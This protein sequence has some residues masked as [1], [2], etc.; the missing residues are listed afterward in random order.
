MDLGEVLARERDE[1]GSSVG[2][3]PR[4]GE[5]S[6]TTES[7]CR[8]DGRPTLDGMATNTRTGTASHTTSAARVPDPHA[9]ESRSAG[10][11]PSPA[12]E[13]LLHPLRPARRRPVREPHGLTAAIG[14]RTT[15]A[16]TA[17]SPARL[18]HRVRHAGAP[19]LVAP[20]A[21]PDHSGDLLGLPDLSGLRLGLRRAWA[22]LA[23]EV[24]ASAQMDAR[25]RARR[26][27][28]SAAMARAGVNRLT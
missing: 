21:V 8:D 20:T 9:L 23:R 24:R 10:H 18:P 16:G 2:F 15:A 22:W 1:H 17:P 11:A 28:D 3:A 13:R 27:E 12:D 4:E 7:F 6:G 25:L 19:R 26:D 5:D 14:G